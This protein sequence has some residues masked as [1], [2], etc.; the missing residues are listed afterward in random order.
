MRLHVREADVRPGRFAL[1]ALSVLFALVLAQV[2]QAQSTT[3]A[4]YQVPDQAI[5]DVVDVLPTP[6]V[7]LG[8]DR[9]WMLLI[10]YPSYPPVA[11]LAERELKLAG[12][13][14]KPSIDGRSR[15]TG[16]IGLSVRRL[17][18]EEPT[19][20]SGLPADPRIGNISW[21]P[22]GAK[23]S[24]THT[25][26]DGIELWVL[27]VESASARRLT[28]ANLSLTAGNAPMWLSDSEQLIAAFVPGD[29]GA[30]PEKPRVPTGPV[31]EESVGR[32]APA[33]TYQDLLKNA[34]DESLFDYYFTT[35][36]A[37]VSLDGSVEPLDE[38]GLLWDFSPS[39]DGRYLL[40]HL[41]LIH[42]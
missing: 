40:V 8:P 25:T 39:P 21:S 7:A 19:S 11:E 20:V 30:E 24:F 2:A 26:T 27:D 16:A 22:D 33:R 9:D 10:Q 36:L 4:V 42:I 28:G 17:Q 34:Y 18:D 29:R 14:I 15:T 1:I 6:A 41:S 5:V 12:M 32:K 23:V 13:R 31:I 3:E 38:P 35:Q 37:R